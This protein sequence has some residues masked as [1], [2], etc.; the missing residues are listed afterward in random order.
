MKIGII[1][2]GGAPALAAVYGDV[3]VSVPK[4]LGALG[5]EPVNELSDFISR[6]GADVAA[7]NRD[8]ENLFKNGKAEGFSHPL[9]D[10][11]EFLPPLPRSPKLFTARGNSA[12]FVRVCKSPVCKQP[13]M[14]QRYNFNLIGHNG[15]HVVRDGY[16][17]GGWN[18]EMVCV[19]GKPCHGAAKENAY[20]YVFGYTNMLDH[21]G[22]YKNY[23]YDEGNKW[24]LPAAEKVF[25]DYAYEGCYNGNSQVPTPI[26]PLIVTKDEV[27][28][29]HDQMLE[30]RE[31]G[32]LIS[33]GGARPSASPSTR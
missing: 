15:L 4:A 25:A 7:L 12:T 3:W 5:L 31:S 1:S 16:A 10:D 19:M 21:S 6:Y 11:L 22:R 30:E 33:Y 29:P 26:G 24:A 13:V 23:P 28:D 2:E 18:Y 9:A 27:G 32:R 14:E 20:D 17:S 8:I